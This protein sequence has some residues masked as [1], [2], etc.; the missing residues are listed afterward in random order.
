[1]PANRAPKSAISVRFWVDFGVQKGAQNAPKRMQKIL[2]KIAREILRREQIHGSVGAGR[3][4][5]GGRRRGGEVNSQEFAI[6]A[7]YLCPYPARRQGAADLEAFGSCRRPQGNCYLLLEIWNLE[8]ATL[9]W[10][11]T[12]KPVTGYR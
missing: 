1:M 9:T 12:S 11:G 5:G 2:R 8:L 7:E 6:Y 3:R 4:H 10:S